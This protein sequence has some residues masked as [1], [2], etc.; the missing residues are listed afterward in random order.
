MAFS[1]DN[2][3]LKLAIVLLAGV[4]GGELVGRLKLPKV[5]GWIGTG[6]VLRT[7][8]VPG[9]DPASVTSF[10]PY[11]SFVL[12][13]ISFTVGAALHVRSLRNAGRRLGLLILCETIITPLVVFGGLY[14]LGGWVGQP[15]GT[16]TSMILAAI[17]IAGAPGTTVLVVQEARAR[18]IL[19]RTLLAAVGLIDMVAVGAFVF[20]FDALGTGAF[21]FAPS[22]VAIEFGVAALSGGGCA[23]LAILL[24]RTVVGP[25]FLGPVMV[26]VILGAWGSAKG[27]GV[28]GILACTMAGIAVSNLQH[29]FVRAAEAYLHAIGGVLFAAFYTF[30]G[31]K[32]DFSQVPAAA[33]LVMLFFLLRL[34]GKSLGAFTAMSIAHVPP[35]VRNYLGMALLPHGGVAVGLILLVQEAPALAGVSEMVTTVGLATLAVNQL[36]GPSATRFALGRAGEVGKDRVRLLD[37]LDEQHIVC[38]VQG[39]TTEDVIRTLCARLY[40]VTPNMQISQDAFEKAVLRPEAVEVSLLGGGIMIPHAGFEGDGEITGVLGLNREGLSLGAPD[41]RPVHAVLLLCTP[42]VHRTRH[43]EILAKFTRALTSD[44]NYREQLY[45]A[46]SA[47]QAYAVLHHEEA[48]DVNY[49]LDD[50]MKRAGVGIDD[51]ADTVTNK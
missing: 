1:F 35:A 22:A 49:F 8:Q 25:A 5:T 11:M 46:R 45:H 16:E 3:L 39:D 30:A 19:T 2:T 13:Y 20:V 26:F 37:F 28:S 24:L 15:V 17:A 47:A 43:V 12:G 44:P 32:L 7:A 51:V 50:A 4:V 21:Q 23:L 48:K 42:N 34:L 29:D 41:G 33:G 6:I 31:M 27:F 9:L 36:L 40:A 38:G 10:S 18:G 14:F